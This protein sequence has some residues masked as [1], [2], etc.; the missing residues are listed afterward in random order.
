MA[1]QLSERL[2]KGLGARVLV[3]VPHRASPER[4]FEVFFIPSTFYSDA[5]TLELGIFCN[6]GFYEW[7]GQEPLQNIDLVSA[8]FPV[9]LSNVIVE[10]LEKVFTRDTEGKLILTGSITTGASQQIE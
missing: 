4:C 2:S 9:S 7:K 6:S 8:G 5:E 3:Y 1:Q 10:V